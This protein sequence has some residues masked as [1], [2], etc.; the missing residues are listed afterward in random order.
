M[1][2]VNAQ[3]FVAV[4]NPDCGMAMINN[5]IYYNET[6]QTES[7]FSAQGAGK[8]LRSYISSVIK[9]RYTKRVLYEFI[10]LLFFIFVDLEGVSQ[11]R[12]P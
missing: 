2:R 6:L 7:S 8:Q 5:Y 10:S 9:V 11:R 1:Y 3:Q 12:V 4:A